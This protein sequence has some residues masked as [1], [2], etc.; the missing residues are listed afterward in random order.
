MNLVF[1]NCKFENL[2]GIDTG[3]ALLVEKCRYLSFMSRNIILCV[4]CVVLCVGGG[5]R[6]I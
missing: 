6:Y 2:N 1:I 4:L 3:G 5:V